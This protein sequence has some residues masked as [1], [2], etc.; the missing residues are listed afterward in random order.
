MQ[1]PLREALAAT[2]STIAISMSVAVSSACR[3]RTAIMTFGQDG[4]RVPLL[5]HALDMGQRL[6]AAWRGPP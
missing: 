4:D 2:S 6:R 1:A 3:P 5:D